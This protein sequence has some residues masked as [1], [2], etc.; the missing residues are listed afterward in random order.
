M[1]AKRSIRIISWNVNGI[2]SAIKKGFADFLEAWQPDIL[3]IQEVRA[4]PEQIPEG[5]LSQFEMEHFFRPADRKGY[6]GVALFT[7]VP[8]TT[9]Q[10]TL[11]VPAFD[12]E[13]RVIAADFGEFVVF[14][15]YFPNGSGNRDNSRVPFKLDFY[16]TLFKRVQ[17][18]RA[19]GREL[20]V[21]GDFNTAHKAIDLARPSPNRKNSGFLPQE[22]SSFQRWIDAGFV[23]TFRHVHGDVP[24]RYSWWSYVGGARARNVGWR[25]DYILCTPGLLPYVKR[26]EIDDEEH[27]SDHCPVR[28]ELEIPNR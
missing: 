13:G 18:V 14:N 1:E 23:D 8:C 27:G 28:L 22:C 16:D 19:S 12:Q 2:R 4:L 21:M 10:A 15:V 20:I 25:I 24:D 9:F 5:A 17:E 26:A 6:S 3:G 7:R 11:D